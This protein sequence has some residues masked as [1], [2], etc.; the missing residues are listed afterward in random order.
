[1]EQDL[2]PEG[3]AKAEGWAEVPVRAEAVVLV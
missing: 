1:M 3:A 2:R